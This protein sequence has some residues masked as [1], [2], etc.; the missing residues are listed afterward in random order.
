MPGK[1]RGVG[2]KGYEMLRTRKK[3]LLVLSAKGGWEVMT[4][5]RHVEENSVLIRFFGR[6]QPQTR[7]D[8]E[9]K[10]HARLKILS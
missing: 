1:H 7:I 2:T 10:R 5:T 9:E 6:K 8:L 4:R 3:R